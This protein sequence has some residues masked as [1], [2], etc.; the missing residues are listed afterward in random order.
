MK[1]PKTAKRDS[2]GGDF[3]FEDKKEVDRRLIEVRQGAQSTRHSVSRDF[4][5]FKQ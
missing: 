5:D 3:F 2:Q 1:P 4:F